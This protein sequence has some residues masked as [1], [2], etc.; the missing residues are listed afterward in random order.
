MGVNF[1]LIVQLVPG[2]SDEAQVPSPPNAKGPALIVRLLIVSVVLPVFE[3]VENCVALVVLTVWFPKLSELGERL[4]VIVTP[5]PDRPTANVEL[6]AT[7]PNVALAGPVAVGLK[8]TPMVQLKSVTRLVPQV[9]LAMANS[10]L[11][12]PVMEGVP[13]LTNK[14]VPFE[15]EIV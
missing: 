13:R 4:A 11:F 6:P 9:L 5:V 14:A 12:V 1:T 7:M 8:V 15:T 10:E 2:A 3:R